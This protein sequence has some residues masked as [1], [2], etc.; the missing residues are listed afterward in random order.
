MEDLYDNND[1][2]NKEINS[3]K[4]FVGDNIKLH[5]KINNVSQLR[6]GLDSQVSKNYIGEIETN[7]RQKSISLSIIFKIT[8]TL[9]IHPALLFLDNNKDKEIIELIKQKYENFNYESYLKS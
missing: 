9:K 7:K 2:N 8:K 4:K 1:E 6:L 5:R 3:F